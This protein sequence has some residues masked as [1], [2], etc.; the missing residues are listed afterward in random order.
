MANNYSSKDIRVLDDI[1]HI[2]LNAE[3]YIGH[4][5]HPTHLIE[6]CFDNA[7]DEAQ[8]GYAN[9]IAI[10]IDTKNK[11]YAILDNGRGL[12]IDDDV[13]IKICTKLFSGSKFRDNKTVYEIASGLHG[14][15]ITAVNALSDY[16]TI[17]I[18]RDNKHAI[19][20]FQ[21]SKFKNKKIEKIEEGF[22]SPFS[23]K[24]QFKPSKSIFDKLTPDIERLKQRL[25]TAS[26]QMPNVTFV[27]NIDDKREL[28][29]LNLKEY[30]DTYVMQKENGEI[31]P[32]LSFNSRNGAEKFNIIMTYSGKGNISSIVSSSVN[33]LPCTSGGTHVNLF[34]EI[35]RDIFVTRAKKLNYNFQPNDCLVGLRAYLMLSLKEVHF[36]AQIKDKLT[37]KKP[38]FDK[39]TAQLKSQIEA[40]FNSNQEHLEILL[41]Y[42]QAY[43]QKLDYK[44]LKVSNNG[45]R[46]FTKFT[47]L[48]DCTSNN[49]ELFLV[50]GDSAGGT[51]VEG[52]NSKIHAIFPMRGK[53]PSIVKKNDIL[54]NKEIR[55]LI[56][57][58]GTGVGNEFNINNIR[59]D[60]IIIA[61]DSD[62]DGLHICCL[63]ILAIGLLT[64]QIVEKGM[65]YYV[66]TPLFAINEKNEF[67]P[68]WSDEELNI[69]RKDNRKVTRFKGLGE[70][71]PDQIYSIAMSDKRKLTQVT[72]SN[73]IDSIIKL[74]IEPNEKRKLLDGTFK[75]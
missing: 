44:K 31:I 46:S 39:L 25:I 42:F 70:F 17:E 56:T 26:V 72:K 43:R 59:Y 60:K 37:N 35:L 57:T 20:N 41:E 12:P 69:A 54:E 27:L 30:F 2:Q 10:N 66:D 19:Y 14:I 4:T 53:I 55:D 74:F 45:K 51:F 18:Y 28:F 38:Y 63:L 24:I 33:L 67:T 9:V 21:D 62:P 5:E 1:K 75:L 13:P 6:E 52:R 15:G 58:F 7:C 64:P 29:K 50:E 48:R 22:Q 32:R 23:T 47:K 36:S 68:L 3:M 40:Y 8:V 49:G 65:L 61:A 34:N 16:I 11:E 71:S 73:H